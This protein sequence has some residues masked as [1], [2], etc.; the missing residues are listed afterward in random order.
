MGFEGRPIGASVGVDRRSLMVF[1]SEFYYKNRPSIGSRKLG[2][3]ISVK[4]LFVILGAN[5]VL[6]YRVD[7]YFVF[8]DNLSSLIIV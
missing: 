6:C 8:L 5:F 1:S 4:R 2:F 3:A 7:L